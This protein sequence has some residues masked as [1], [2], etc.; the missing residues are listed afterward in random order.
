M[1]S[2]PRH[3][4]STFV[5]SVSTT[6]GLPYRP[7]IVRHDASVTPSIGA[8]PIIGCSNVS[9]KDPFLIENP[10]A[11]ARDCPYY[12]TASLPVSNQPKLLYPCPI[13]ERT[14]SQ[15]KVFLTII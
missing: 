9:Q 1:R 12:T 6:S 5:N 13:K 3:R 10:G 11:T 7:C 15:S 2:L 4:P 8:N 14:S